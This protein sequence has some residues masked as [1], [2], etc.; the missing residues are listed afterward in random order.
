MLTTSLYS[1]ELEVHS[2]KVKMDENLD[3]NIKGL[4]CSATRLDLGGLMMASVMR[5]GGSRKLASRMAAHR[6]FIFPVSSSTGFHACFDDFYN[7]AFSPVLFR[8][9]LR[10]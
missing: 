5:N 2:N 10:K 6:T 9:S 1:P 8:F 3:T 4:H 7:T